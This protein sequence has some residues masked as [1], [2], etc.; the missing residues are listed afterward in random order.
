MPTVLTG[1][2]LFVVFWTIT[3]LVFNLPGGSDT[4]AFERL[5]RWREARR[6]TGAAGRVPAG[7]ARATRP[8]AGIVSGAPRHA[9]PV[10][11]PPRG[12]SFAKHQA[13]CTVYDRVLGELCAALGIEHLLGVLPPG[14][15]RDAERTRIETALWLA[16]LRVEDAA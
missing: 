4:S 1:A 9:T 16:G 6:D 14:E 3:W 7:P 15:E 13:F 2:A 10:H 12:T 8:L 11:E 5:G